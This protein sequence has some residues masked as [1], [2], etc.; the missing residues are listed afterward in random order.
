MFE[1]RLQA[2]YA[3]LATHVEAWVLEE[4]VELLAAGEWGV[5]FEAAADNL[6]EASISIFPG[7]LAELESLGRALESQ[8]RAW[9][10]LHELVVPQ[11]Q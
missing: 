6:Y 11:P 3:S 4:P 5:S 8:R 2:L 9:T 7:E 1:A 10:L